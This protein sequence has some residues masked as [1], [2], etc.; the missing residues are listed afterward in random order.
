MSDT[1]KKLQGSPGFLALP[2]TDPDGAEASTK[3]YAR[4]DLSDFA[5]QERNGSPINWRYWFGMSHITPEQ[6][7]KLTY[8]IDPLTWDKDNFAQG[9][10]EGDLR[11]K[12]ARLRNA[13]EGQDRTLSEITAFLGYPFAPYNMEMAASAQ[14]P[15]QSFDHSALVGRNVE[16]ESPPPEG[17]PVPNWKL[18]VQ[19]EAANMF[20]RARISGASPTVHSIKDD[21]ATW[22]RQQDIKTDGGIY[23]S[24]EYLRVHVLSGRHWQKPV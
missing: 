22:C 5:E 4:M 9:Q 23:P 7:A 19:E 15:I 6:G 11:E 1:Q 2:G 10:I 20:K 16:K 8:C 17:V 12:I 13:L 18:R 14:I 3:L 24:G 21:L